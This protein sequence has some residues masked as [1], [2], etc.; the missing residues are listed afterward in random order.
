M[1][2]VCKVKETEQPE[3]T[4]QVVSPR[5]FCSPYTLS[6]HWG[7]WCMPA[8]HCSRSGGGNIRRKLKSTL[9]YIVNLEPAW[10]T[11]VH[12]RQPC[13]FTAAF[14][15]GRIDAK[16]QESTIGIEGK[17][18]YPAYLGLLPRCIWASGPPSTALP[19]PLSVSS[20]ILSPYAEIPW[21]KKVNSEYEPW[22]KSRRSLRITV[23]IRLISNIWLSGSP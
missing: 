6:I 2:S 22:S 19:W 9:C 5:D 1:T 16:H 4:R 15:V 21:D 3:V 12:V 20:C 8:I 7:L 18:Q 14:T 13:V 10:A 11:S 17:G 23:N